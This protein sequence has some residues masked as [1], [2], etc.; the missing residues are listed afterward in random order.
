M[1]LYLDILIICIINTKNV[2]NTILE[3]FNILKWRIML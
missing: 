3:S 2:I 1:N